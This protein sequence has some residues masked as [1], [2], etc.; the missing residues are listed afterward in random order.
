MVGVA[1]G[2]AVG[3]EVGVTV[4]VI[5]SVG[6]GVADGVGVWE[7]S[8]TAG[9]FA[10]GTHPVNRIQT[11]RKNQGVERIVNITTSFRTNIFDSDMIRGCQF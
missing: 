11:I 4:G 7:R 6:V 5:V 1:V 10:S 3:V 2:A 8:I 9:G